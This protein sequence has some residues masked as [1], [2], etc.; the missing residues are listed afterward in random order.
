[1][2]ETGDGVPWEGQPTV[3]GQLVRS[4]RGR[5][6]DP[7][8]RPQRHGQPILLPDGSL[9]LDEDETTPH[10]VL[11]QVHRRRRDAGVQ[12]GGRAPGGDHHDIWID[13][14]NADRMIVAHDQG[15]SISE[16]RGRT[17]FRQ[18]LSNAQIYHVTVDNAIPYNVLGN[19]QDEPSYRGPSNSRVPGGREAGISRGMWA[20]VGGGESVWPRPTP[21]IPTSCG[22]P[23]RL[24]LVGG[25]VVR[26]EGT[27][28]SS[29]TSKSV[30]AIHGPPEGVRYRFVWTPAP[31]SPPITHLTSGASTSST[32]T[33]AKLAGHQPG[34]HLNDKTAR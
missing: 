9:T 5:P 1:M 3:T 33:A 23:R 29:A 22:P 24:R 4:T 8:P 26:F 20:F 16:N 7:G 14:G 27:G 15:L 19:K 12:T 34:P 25:I 13:P 6:L 30:L 10:R 18:R 17:W 31:H 2:I 32:R 28:A 11:L 21:P